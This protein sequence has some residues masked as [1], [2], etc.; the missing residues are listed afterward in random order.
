[1]PGLAAIVNDRRITIGELSEECIDRH[2]AEALDGT[3]N[4]H[5]LEQQLLRSKHLE[6]AQHD[7]Q[8]EVARA[9]ISVGKVTKKGDADIEG[10]LALVTKEQGV[11]TDLYIR[12][13]VWP[14][15]ALKKIT[16]DVQVSD[17]DLQKGFEA[18]YGK[19]V[20]CRAIVLTSQRRAQ[21]VWQLARHELDKPQPNPAF[22]G[23][24]AEQYSV[25][26]SKTLQG[27]V[28]PIQRYGGTPMLER[29]AFTLKPGD[30][31]SIV[32]IGEQYVILFCEGYTEP[33]K[34]Q[35]AEV[36]DLLVDD[37]HEK[38]MRMAMAD[39][40]N[41][42]KDAAQIDNFLTGSTHSP[43]SAAKAIAGMMKQDNNGHAQFVTPTGI[44]LPEDAPTRNP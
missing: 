6:V 3:I 32:Q 23:Q 16:G 5:L 31:S 15:V 20:R 8:V 41:R 10:W 44:N 19:R 4:R 39:E 28:P 7:L 21:E 17:E 12:D 27:R 30:L 35:M 18:N 43:K 11:S 2:G 33:Q 25:D 24:L 34:V 14:T 13:A 37:I 38:K 9:A 36:H 26:P 29:E 40:F 1:M 42:I 22:F